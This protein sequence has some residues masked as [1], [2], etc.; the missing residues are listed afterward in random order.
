MHH[1]QAEC[2]RSTKGLKL[3]RIDTAQ[4][5]YSPVG[6]IP[7]L[8]DHLGN[9]RPSPACIYWTQLSLTLNQENGRSI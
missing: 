9:R 6:D 7:K 8:K 2:Q 1:A 3:K 5:K 4:N